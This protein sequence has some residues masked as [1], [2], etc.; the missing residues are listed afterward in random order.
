MLILAGLV[1]DPITKK[2]KK[3]SQSINYDGIKFILACKE[4]NI[5]RLIFV[6]IC[7]NYGIGKKN[8]L[9]KRPN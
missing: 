1:G 7:S 3:L 5:K 4:K 8:C 2:Y 9:M 6:S